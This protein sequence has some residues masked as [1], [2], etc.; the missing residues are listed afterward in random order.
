ME[1]LG[2]D[3]ATKLAKLLTTKGRRQFGKTLLDSV[4]LVDEGLNL[5]LV[6][7]LIFV[8]GSDSPCIEKAEQAGVTCTP[9]SGEHFDKLCSVKSS[10]GVVA[11][12]RLPE[13]LSL[14]GDNL[15]LADRKFIVYLDQISNPG[16]L[17]TIARSVAAFG[18]DLLVLSPDCADPFSPKSLRASAGALL[19]LNIAHGFLDARPEWP[20]FYR[21]M[22]RGGVD[23]GQLAVS[24]RCGLW[25]GNEGHGPRDVVDGLTVTDVSIPMERFAESLNVTA[26]ASILAY[27]LASKTPGQ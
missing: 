18:C 16:N 22:S 17:G 24:G 2:K 23:S 26:A 11:V 9:C 13:P 19:R 14:T 4:P 3:R 27:V 5:G 8:E 10:P 1:P 12:T 15:E 25:L 7:E 20:T 21:A 6:E